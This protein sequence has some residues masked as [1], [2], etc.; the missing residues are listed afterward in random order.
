[1]ER[2]RKFSWGN[3]S[4]AVPAAPFGVAPNGSSKQI[5]W[6]VAMSG[7]TPDMA[8]ETRALPKFNRIALE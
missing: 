2:A 7:A 4:A 1:L 3:G 8:R 6:L 5:N